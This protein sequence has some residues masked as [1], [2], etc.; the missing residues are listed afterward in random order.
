MPSLKEMEALKE[1][2]NNFDD[3]ITLKSGTIVT[4]PR[5]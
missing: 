2:A 1:A 3:E 5:G 4:A